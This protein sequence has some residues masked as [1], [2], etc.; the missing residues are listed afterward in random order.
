MRADLL[1]SPTD[2]Q[3]SSGQPCCGIGNLGR[4]GSSTGVDGADT[5][6]SK[7]AGGAT[8]AGIGFGQQYD[9]IGVDPNDVPHVELAPGSSTDI[10]CFE[11][12][13]S[14]Q[15]VGSS[16]AGNS[17]DGDG[18]TNM[19]GTT[20]LPD[21]EGSQAREDDNSA[22]MAPRVLR[23]RL[24]HGS[25]HWSPP[26]HVDALGESH[27]FL[28]P[29]GASTLVSPHVPSPLPHANTLAQTTTTTEIGRASCRERV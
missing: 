14:H 26:L 22:R 16:V 24:A 15:P 7:G 12:H 8:H 1:D 27:F 29:R 18:S 5:D 9:T 4:T 17:E 10:Y 3:G 2:E 23:F 11:S 20:T 25:W 21:V 19:H 6:T 13:S 28:L